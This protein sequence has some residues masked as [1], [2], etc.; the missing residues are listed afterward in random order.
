[1]PERESRIVA[2]R[3]G[4]GGGVN[5]FRFRRV[6]LGARGLRPTTRSATFLAANYH[7]ANMTKPAHLSLA[8]HCLQAILFIIKTTTLGR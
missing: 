6:E 1:M 8:W 7:T 5:V 4:G 3:V 2:S